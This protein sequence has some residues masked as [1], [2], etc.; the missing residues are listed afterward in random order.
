M[1]KLK[2]CGNFIYEKWNVF[3][4]LLLAMWNFLQYQF[5]YVKS[6]HSLPLSPA[7]YRSIFKTNLAGFHRLTGLGRIWLMLVS[8][9]PR[10]KL[11]NKSLYRSHTVEMMV[12]VTEILIMFTWTRDNE[13]EGLSLNIPTFSSDTVSFDLSLNILIELWL[14]TSRCPVKS[15]KVSLAAFS[16][17][18]T[19]WISLEIRTN[20]NL[21]RNNL[22]NVHYIIHIHCSSLFIKIIIVSL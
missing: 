22:S 8:L 9:E 5:E 12:V 7:P 1:E 6:V 17:Q 3:K 15:S 13:V 16:A 14:Q 19:C 21:F 20:Q 18:Q 11:F 10:Q 2:I 4:R